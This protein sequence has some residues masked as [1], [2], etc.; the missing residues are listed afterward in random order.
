MIQ[1]VLPCVFD[2]LEYSWVKA[3]IGGMLR[4][5][6]PASSR[7][8]CISFIIVRVT[9]KPS[10]KSISG[11]VKLELTKMNLSSLKIQRKRK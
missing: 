9:M 3:T 5:V 8:N 2:T 4:V 10:S 6:P 7:V 11:L 1:L